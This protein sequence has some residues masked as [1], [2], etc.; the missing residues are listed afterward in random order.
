MFSRPAKILNACDS[1]YLNKEETDALLA[2]TNS[3]P[4]RLAAAKAVEQKEREAVQWTLDELKKKY[5][6]FAGQHDRGWEKGFRDM[7]LVTRYLVQGMLMDDLDVASEKLLYWMRTITACFGLTQQFHRDS[8]TLL[9]DAFKARLPADA[10]ALMA[11][12]F[13]RTIEVLT[14]IPEPYKPAV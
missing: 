1:R 7:Q 14:D 12:H 4:K 6:N 10:Y 2:Y 8:Y 3:V 9:R 11:P 13:E 5:P